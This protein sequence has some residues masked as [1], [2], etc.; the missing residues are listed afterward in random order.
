MEKFTGKVWVLGD[1]I[2]TDIIIP[3]EYLALK[4]ID[5]MKQYGF[6]PL[7]P[8]LAGQISKG[9]IIVAGKNFGCGSSREQAPEIIKA[10]GIRCVIARSFARI[11]F[12]NSI[13]NGLLL[14]ENPDLRDV[15]TEG[16]KIEVTVGEKVVCDG[17]EYPIASLP[18]NLMDIINAG[19]L[20]KAMRQ[21][22][23]LED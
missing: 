22:N 7:R 4:T 12:R 2:D 10:L 19:G 14:I 21:L 17:K 9:D 1:D 15:V 13:N 23:G 5:D 20:V 16:E 8:E 6:S 3:T 18:Q 11:F